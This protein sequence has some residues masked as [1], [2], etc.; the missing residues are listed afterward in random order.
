[1]KRARS[2]ILGPDAAERVRALMRLRW[3]RRLRVGPLSLSRGECEG[4]TLW[5]FA[6]RTSASRA[7]LRLAFD[8]LRDAGQV[9]RQALA[10]PRP[11]TSLSRARF[12]IPL[13]GARDRECLLLERDVEDPELGWL[14]LCVSVDAPCE[15]DASDL[16]HGQE[17][18]ILAARVIH[19]H[20]IFSGDGNGGHRIDYM[21]CF[22]LGGSIPRRVESLLQAGFVC[23]TGIELLA[24]VR[25][26]RSEVA[27]A[28]VAPQG[29]R[30]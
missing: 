25:R 17:A 1:M 10:P 11:D 4:L 28:A 19:S 24:R 7:I 16:L 23:V 22:R 9:E 13:P 29:K 5:R 14:N 6:A 3:S 30:Q 26:V 27:Q 8:S 18:P 12:R 21:V 2:W 20:F 15:V